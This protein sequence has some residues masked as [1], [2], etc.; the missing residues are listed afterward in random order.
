[1]SL[2]LSFD[3]AQS[4]VADTTARLCADCCGD[5]LLRAGAGGFDIELWRALAEQGLLA[6]LT[7]QGFGG[8][9]ELVAALESLGRAVFPGPLPATFLATQLLPEKERTGVAEGAGT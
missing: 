8:A 9:G 7:P 5:D 3:D 4:A 1:M 2:D 6:L